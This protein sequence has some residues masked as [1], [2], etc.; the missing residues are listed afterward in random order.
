[1]LTIH[2]CV[3]ELLN[4]TLV[5]RRPVHAWFLKIDPV[6]IVI[7]CVCVFVCIHPRGY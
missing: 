6:Q 5:S 4:Q 7:I 2:I 3:C 1:M